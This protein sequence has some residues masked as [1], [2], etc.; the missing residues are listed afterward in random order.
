MT[1][2]R[3]YYVYALKD[4]LQTPPIPFYVGKG[5]GVRAWEHELQTDDSRKG[6]RIA[7]IHDAK[8]EVTVVKLVEGLTESESLRVEAEL[9]SAF[10]VESRG[11]LLTNTVRPNTNIRASQKLTLAIPSGVYEKAQ[12]GLA[13]IENAV[14]ELAIANERGVTNSEV[15]HGLGLQ[16]E[17]MGGS[18][19]Y[20]SWS[21]LGLLM[22][23][24]RMKRIEKKR[25]QAQVR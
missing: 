12:V 18:K 2:D 15:S 10:G 24:G 1:S 13:L 16:S 6:R 19:D 14:M 8:R 7:A 5:T 3:S 17:Y 20:L 11:G 22:R 25:H 9:I 23:Q 21:I 4:P